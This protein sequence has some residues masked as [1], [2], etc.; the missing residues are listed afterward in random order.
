MM[1]W[2]VDDPVQVRCQEHGDADSI[3]RVR[4]GDFIQGWPDLRDVVLQ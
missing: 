3:V 4:M 1:S 2:Q